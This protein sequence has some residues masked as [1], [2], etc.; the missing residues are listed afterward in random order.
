MDLLLRATDTIKSLRVCL[1]VAQWNVLE[2]SYL[3]RKLASLASGPQPNFSIINAS[4]DPLISIR[5]RRSVPLFL[6]LCNTL[7]SVFFL[8]SGYLTIPVIFQVAIDLHA[9]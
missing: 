6:T 3:S 5:L 9:F 7:T 8:D 1:L 4:Q 2:H